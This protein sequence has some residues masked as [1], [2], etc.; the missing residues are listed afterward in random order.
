LKKAIKIVAILLG[1]VILGVV[2]LAI[3]VP[4]LID[5]N[6]Y[7]DELVQAVK[8]R[9]GRELKV[10][11][12]IDLSIF[13]WLGVE[14]DRVEFANAPGFGKDPFAQVASAGVRVKVLPLLSREVVVDTIHMDGLRLNLIKNRTG[15]TNWDDL[16]ATDTS[17]SQGEASGAGI[18]ALTIGGINIRDG[19]ISWRD[20]KERSRY[21]L[22]KLTL[23]SGK[24]VPGEPVDLRASFDLETGEPPKQIPIELNTRVNLDLE[25]QAL[26]IPKLVLSVDTMELTGQVTGSKIIDAPVLQGSL[27]IGSFDARPLMKKLAIEVAPG[28]EDLLADVA[29]KTDFSA[30]LGRQ[31][32]QLGNL[33]LKA[34]ALAMTGDIK[35]TQLDKAPQASGRVTIPPL[36]PRA[37]MKSFGITYETTD[38]GALAKLGLSS[39]FSASADHLALK[40]LDAKLDESALRGSLTIRNFSKPSYTFDL[41]IDQIDLDRYLAPAEDTAGEQDTVAALPLDTLRGLKLKGQLRVNKLKAFGLRSTNASM[42]LS[43]NGGLVTVGPSQAKLYGGS[44]SGQTKVDARQK[45]PKFIINEKLTGIDLEPFL[46][47]AQIYENFSGIGNVT[48]SLTARGANT[49]AVVK[50]LTGKGAISARNG[51]IKGVNL[52]QSINDAKAKYDKLRGK[53]VEVTPKATDESLFSTFNATFN[54]R[55]GVARNDDLRLQGANIR[56]TG[57]GTANLTND[58]VDY[59]LYVTV[60]EDASRKGTTVP[61]DISGTLT[62]PQYQVAWNEVLKAQAKKKIETKKAKAEEEAKAKLKAKKKKKK[63]ELKEKLRKKLGLE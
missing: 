23:K 6:D 15:K 41:T 4:L 10:E 5:P 22:H 20:D 58:K 21:A 48:M 9:T 8:E 29:L 44:Y 59:R 50:T 38:K 49:D 55:N 13:P 18:A 12:D 34:G 1:I 56:A 27:D 54:I 16:M 33:S 37:L 31:T 62:Q 11:G 53:S 24:I 40:K 47:D 46:K 14:M 30:D 26:D 7:K 25:S 60:A 63:D 39:E 52:Q 61:V 2:V 51:K 17:A 19:D 28:S 57:K 32:L 43:A 3:A 36:D 42:K 35:V 45:T